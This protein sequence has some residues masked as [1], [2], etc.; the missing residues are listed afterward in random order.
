MRRSVTEWLIFAAVLSAFVIV[1]TP[2]S[3]GVPV[4][5]V[6][7]AGTVAGVAMRKKRRRQ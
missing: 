6:I 1:K 4:A 2:L 5:L 3:V 7:A